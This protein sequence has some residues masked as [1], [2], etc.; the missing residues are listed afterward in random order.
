MVISSYTVATILAVFFP[1]YRKWFGRWLGDWW[2]EASVQA[3][4]LHLS[5]PTHFVLPWPRMNINGH[6]HRH[7]SRWEVIE[8]EVMGNEDLEFFGKKEVTTS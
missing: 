8:K 2:G 4:L 3:P 1:P 7:W 6:G 5:A